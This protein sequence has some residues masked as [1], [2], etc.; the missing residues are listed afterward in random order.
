MGYENG[1]LLLRVYHKKNRQLG[2]RIVV[3]G[4]NI[5]GNQAED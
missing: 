3:M 5:T 4:Y 1:T 2:A